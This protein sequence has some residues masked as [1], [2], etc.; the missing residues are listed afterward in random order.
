MKEMQG[1]REPNFERFRKVL[2]LEGEPDR[3]PFY[4]LFADQE[5]MT[6]ILGRPVRNEQD[7]VEYQLLI[8]YDYVHAPLP[9]CGFPTTGVALADDTAIIPRVKRHFDQSTMGCIK[10]WADFEAYPWPNP[11]QFDF[12]PLERTV[13]VL[14]DGMKIKLLLGHVLEDPM[15]L[16][17]YADLS[18][19]LY[20][21]PELVEAVFDRV[22]RLYEAAYL[23]CAPVDAVGFLEISDDLGFKT[24][25]MFSPEML[26]RYVFPW[27]KRYCDICHEYDKPVV[28]HSCGNLAEIM[29]DLIA[30]GINAKHSYEDQIMPVQEVKA[31]YGKHWAV[32]GGIDVDFLCRATEEEVRR[33]VRAVLDACMPGGGYALGTGNS[34]ANYIP[35]RNFLAMIDVGREYGVYSQTD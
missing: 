10:S 20:D 12:S 19:A 6:A 13:R 27:Y 3:V 29:D 22:G 1:T 18:V 24:A 30:C 23:A 31:R 25:T 4:E 21:E 2:M 9:G 33:H 15:R 8:G 28:L 11:S 34:V 14:P 16:M 32:L 35:V 17:G 7:L 26:R 5:I